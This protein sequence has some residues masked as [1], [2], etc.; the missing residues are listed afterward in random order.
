MS[1]PI[2]NAKLAAG[3]TDV[4][5]AARLAGLRELTVRLVE[6]EDD[7]FADR[8]QVGAPELEV[9]LRRACCT[10]TVR[11]SVGAGVW[12]Q[13]LACV[14]QDATGRGAVR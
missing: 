11:V 3:I 2:T 4:S 9:T 7:S 14:H 6:A 1:A 8:R 13:S 10:V 12:G 5:G